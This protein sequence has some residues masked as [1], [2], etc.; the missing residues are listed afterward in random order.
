MFVNVGFGKD[1]GIRDGWDDGAENGILIGVKVGY[2][3]GLID[4]DGLVD[5]DPDGIAVMLGRDDG[6]GDED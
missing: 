2:E 3:L 6:A 1:D 5:G 4:T